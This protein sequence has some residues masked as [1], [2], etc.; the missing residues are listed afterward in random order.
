M[1]QR[2]GIQP[3]VGTK[4]TSV[5]SSSGIP[6][7]FEAFQVHLG[8]FPANIHDFDGYLLTGST[9]GAYELIPWI[10]ELRERLVDIRRAKLPMVGVCF[11]HQLIAHALG[12]K[13]AKNQN[14]WELGTAS[15]PLSQ[16]GREKLQQL[17]QRSEH[18]ASLEIPLSLRL[19]AVH[20]D[21]V[22]IVP[23][24]FTSLGGNANTHCEGMVSDDLTVLT[25]QGHPEFTAESVRHLVGVLESHINPATDIPGTHYNGVVS[26]ASQ[27]VSKSELLKSASV[28]VHADANLVARLA[29]AVFGVL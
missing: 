5:S 16:N 14:G 18:T 3:V 6:V 11:G 12:G 9:N 21:E 17:A 19:A 28:D 7:E 10:E 13:A 25:V 8:E 20:G 29:L 4:E 24:G 26:M 15:F 23:P 22:A 1:F 27:G 2:V